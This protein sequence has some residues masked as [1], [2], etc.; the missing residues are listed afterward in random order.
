MRQQ[1]ENARIELFFLPFSG[2]NARIQ[3]RYPR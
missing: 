3:E 2:S 1:S